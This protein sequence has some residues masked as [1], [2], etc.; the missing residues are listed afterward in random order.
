MVLLCYKLFLTT[1]IYGHCGCQHNSMHTYTSMTVMLTQEKGAIS[2]F[3]TGTN[4]CLRDKK[5]EPPTVLING[6]GNSQVNNQGLYTA[7]LLTGSQAPQKQYCMSQTQNDTS[8]LDI[9][10]TTDR[11]HTLHKDSSHQS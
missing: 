11:L 7:V 9:N 10:S 6:Y 1:G 4:L 3:C 5:P 8:S 2:C